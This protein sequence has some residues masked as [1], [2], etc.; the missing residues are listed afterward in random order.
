VAQTIVFRRLRGLS[1]GTDYL[2][3]R[4]RG[5]QNACTDEIPLACKT[6]C[7]FSNADL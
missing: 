3:R 4:L 7:I 5:S 2:F 6:T 1:S